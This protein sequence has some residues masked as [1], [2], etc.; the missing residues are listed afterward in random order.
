MTL[1]IGYKASAEQFG[2]R[3]LVELGVLAEEVGLD[4]VMVSDHLQPWRHIGGHAPSALACLAAI[5]EHT[6]RVVVGTSVLLGALRH[7]EQSFRIEGAGPAM[8]ALVTLATLVLVMPS[9]TVGGGPTTY[10]LPQLAF[11]AASD[12]RFIRSG[13]EYDGKS[14]REHLERKFGYARSMLSTADQFID[15]IAT[16]SSLTGEA[17]KVRCG[18]REI[19]S[20]AWL[21][22][23][24]DAYRKSG[25]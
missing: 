10:S 2:P 7:R 13:D 18:T 14:A 16:G 9:F 25:K 4:S 3:E 17:Y 11:V 21:R 15:H 6:E 5:G 1:K 8:A 24:L 19:T 20:K 23:E 12:C 22:G